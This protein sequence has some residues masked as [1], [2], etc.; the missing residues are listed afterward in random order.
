[1]TQHTKVKAVFFDFMGTCVDWHSTAVKAMPSTLPEAEASRIAIAWHR[2]YFAENAKL[3][4]KNAPPEDI[5]QT[6]ARALDIVLDL[7][8]QQRDHFDRHAR[9]KLVTNWHRQLAW[10]DSKK[11]IDTL[12]DE[13]GLDVIVHG[14][15]T[16]RMQMDLCRSSGLSFNM[17]FSSLLIG[18]YKP[19]PRAYHKV[20]ELVKL[21]PDEVVM[22][23]AHAYDLRG[24]QKCGLRTIYIHRWTDDTDENMVEVRSEFD[25][26]LEGMEGLPAAV[27]KMGV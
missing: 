3:A 1:M 6:L 23:A 4:S 14:N 10:P 19:D 16:P 26:Y 20:L 27:K 24:A 5:D 21:S 8:H 22:V 13:L 15:G 9:T 25:V 12:R 7:N 2:Q 11:A 18:F 17:L